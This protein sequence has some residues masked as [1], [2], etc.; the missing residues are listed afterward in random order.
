V[1]E[2]M[3]SDE[4]VFSFEERCAAGRYRAFESRR[5][6]GCYRAITEYRRHHFFV[7]DR[8]RIVLLLCFFS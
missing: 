2:E 6:W 4:V 3:G 5:D 8:L 7:L 1:R